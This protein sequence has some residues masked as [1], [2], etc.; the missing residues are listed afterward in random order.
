MAALSEFH[1][2]T[3]LQRMLLCAKIKTQPSLPPQHC[4]RSAGVGAC[5]DLVFDIVLPTPCISTTFWLCN[6]V[7]ATT[8][9]LF[10][11]KFSNG[12]HE[13][14]F[15]LLIYR[16]YWFRNYKTSTKLFPFSSYTAN[17]SV[18]Y[19]AWQRICIRH[20]ILLQKLFLT[21]CRTR[22]LVLAKLR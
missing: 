11:S 19:K 20:A 16:R 12:F 1:Y 7:N 15:A 4:A 6:F 21:T 13:L 8:P 14:I 5:E 2:V 10:C 9:L 22:L 18:R 3:L 17:G